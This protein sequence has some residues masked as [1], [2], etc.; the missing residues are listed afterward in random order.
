MKILVVGDYITDRYIFGTASR[1]CPEA[2]VPVVVPQM[3]RVSAGGAGLVHAQ[4]AELG[5]EVL[6]WA[7]SRSEKTR[8]F[9]DN[10]LVVRVDRDSQPY[11]VVPISDFLFKDMDL[12]VVSDYGKGA[13]TRELAARLI[14]SAKPTFVDAKHQWDWYWGP[15]TWTFPNEHEWPIHHIQGV[16]G[17]GY[18]K[19]TDRVV[20]KL[21][22]HG[23]KMGDL[24]LPATVSDVA[25]VTGAGDIFMAGFVFAW[26]LQ[27]P[28]EDCLRFANTLAGESCRHVGTY[29][30]PQVFAKEVLD[31]LRVL[32]VSA[33][34]IRVTAPDSNLSMLQPPPGLDQS[35]SASV[36]ERFGSL[37]EDLGQNQ[38]GR[39]SGPESLP[40]GKIPP[41]G[42]LV[43][44]ELH[45]T[46]IPS[47][48]GIDYEPSTKPPWEG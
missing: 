21:G 13:F 18:E 39:V 26:S 23:C 30:V 14:A 33:R 6:L 17:D 4:L 27:L 19:V 34:P 37:L 35:W 11:P 16:Y 45:A 43:P 5:A 29:V 12:I 15:Q 48:S 28:A 2:P 7:G 24:Q 9:A 44:T 36:A 38:L 32:R 25:D 42:P 46:P 31:T 3:E 8:I 47:G 20:Q 22:P 41:S 1:L 10:R 40:T